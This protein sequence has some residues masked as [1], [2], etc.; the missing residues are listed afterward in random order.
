MESKVSHVFSCAELNAVVEMM[1]RRLRD[2][3]MASFIMVNLV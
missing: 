3:I 1:K 2:V